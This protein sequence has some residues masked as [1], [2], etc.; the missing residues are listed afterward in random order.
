MINT[1]EVWP[2]VNNLDIL[3]GYIYLAAGLDGGLTIFE[4]Y[5]TP[6]S[7]C[8]NIRG[9]VNGDP[10]D[11][12]NISDLVALVAYMFQGGTTPPCLEEAD[13]DGSETINI[14]DLVSLIAY[15]FQGGTAPANCP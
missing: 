5:C 9:N 6:P 4:K 8:H 15:M 14:S 13:I 11:Q 7:C 1:L 2:L 3:N 12:I 10:L